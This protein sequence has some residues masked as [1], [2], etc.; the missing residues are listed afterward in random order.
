MVGVGNGTVAG[1]A[2]GAEWVGLCW[3]DFGCGVVGDAVGMVVAAAVE[4]PEMWL[5]AVCEMVV[6]GMVVM[7]RAMACKGG[8]DAVDA[9][10]WSGPW[11]RMLLSVCNGQ[12]PRPKRAVAGAASNDSNNI[13]AIGHP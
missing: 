2:G 12:C 9:C 13:A 8:R 4:R 3:K 6:C 10:G 11:G 7:S 5:P 1:G